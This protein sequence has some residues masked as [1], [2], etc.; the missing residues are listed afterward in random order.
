[1]GL[2][3]VFDEEPVKGRYESD[4]VGRFRSG[5]VSRGKPVS[6]TQFRV[7]TGDPDVAEVISQELGGEPQEWETDKDDKIEIFTTTD[8]VDVILDGPGAIRTG[9]VSFSRTN[10]LLRACDGRTQTGGDD[11][12]SP[13]AC[14]LA[15]QERKD[16]AARGTG[17]SP[18]ILVT[19]KLSAFPALGVFQF[20]SGSWTLAKDISVAEA[21]L[22]RIDGPALATLSLEVV[23]WVD[24]KTNRE[25]S[26]TKPV[27]VI[28]KGVQNE[29]SPF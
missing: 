14:P 23:T 7:T 3:G 12:G 6:L 15:L 4:V 13:C 5:H 11:E 24:K 21:A 17:C 18:S 22:A 29:S 27:L 20:R 10:Q 2:F 26:F 28:R 19:F 16:A 1:M 25:K 9:L 8:S